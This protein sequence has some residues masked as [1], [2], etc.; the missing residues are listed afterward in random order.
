MSTNRTDTDV[1]HAGAV[2][3]GLEAMKGEGA[4]TGLAPMLSLRA[5]S[6]LMQL[7]E[8]L[9]MLRWRKGCR[10]RTERSQMHRIFF[11]RRRFARRRIVRCT[12]NGR[13]GP[14]RR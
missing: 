13:G 9:R 2:S 11:Q 12:R 4:R 5:E 3:Y 6:G 8:T 1:H 14:R 7:V 10:P